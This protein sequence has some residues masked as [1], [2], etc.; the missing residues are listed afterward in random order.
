MPSAVFAAMAPPALL[1]MPPE[2]IATDSTWMPD[3][4][5]D[6]PS[7]L[8]TPLLV[9]PLVKSATPKT[10]M[11][12]PLLVV[13]IVPLPSRYLQSQMTLAEAAA[14]VLLGLPSSRSLKNRF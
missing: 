1:T 5:P 8:I 3:P 6:D 9:T 4:C 7:A 2:K 10:A 13:T 11:P 12:A 14:V